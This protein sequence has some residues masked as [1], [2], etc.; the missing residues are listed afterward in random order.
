MDHALCTVYYCSVGRVE[1]NGYDPF[2]SKNVARFCVYSP[3]WEK[4]DIG[5]WIIIVKVV[6][7]T[8]DS[9][10]NALLNEISIEIESDSCAFSNMGIKRWALLP[11]GFYLL[12]STYIYSI[13]FTYLSS[14]CYILLHAFTWAFIFDSIAAGGSMC[15][16]LYIRFY[17]K[18]LHSLSYG[19]C[20]SIS[21]LLWFWFS[22]II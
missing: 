22:S 6:T 8:R 2:W 14:H 12:S 18:K 15:V 20:V 17:Y 21:F 16:Y 11:V 4:I 1:P 9:W 5:I 3:W 7:V 13:L 19:V 10:F